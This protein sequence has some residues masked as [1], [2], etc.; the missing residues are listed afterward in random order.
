VRELTRLWLQNTQ[1]LIED[2]EGERLAQHAKN[3]PATQAIVELGSH[4]GLSTC[5]MAAGSRDGNGAHITAVDP[6]GKPRP[7][8]LDD[9]WDL[10]P[11]GVLERFQSNIAG[12]TQLVFNEDYGDIVTPLRMKS[13]A[14]SRVWIKPI[15]L[16]FVDAIHEGPAVLEDWYSWSPHLAPGAVVCFHDYGDSYPGVK[17][18]IDREI[19]PSRRWIWQ[20]L[21]EPSLWQGQLPR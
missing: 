4:T 6:W 15:G 14:A 2:S 19:E 10:G 12:T 7:G 1:G 8:S 16:L 13:R 21:T 18:A 11:D 9:P 5:W 3:V 20:D 17:E